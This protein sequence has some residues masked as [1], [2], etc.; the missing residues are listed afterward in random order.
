MAA[1]TLKSMLPKGLYGR[2]ALIL[3]FP[4]IVV[5]LVV[6]IVFIQRHFDGVTRQMTN[7][8]VV[9]LLLVRDLLEGADVVMDCLDSIDTRFTLQEAAQNKEIPIVSGAIAGVTGR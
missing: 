2:A 1:P 4:L 3:I 8:I 6:S 9:E 7:N 5:Q